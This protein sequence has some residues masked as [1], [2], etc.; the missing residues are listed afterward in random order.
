[1]T[2]RRAEYWLTILYVGSM[3]L[4]VVSVISLVTAWQ[5]WAW[6]LDSCIEVDCG[7]ILYGVN[8]FSTFLGGDVKLCHFGS[9]GLVPV[10][11]ISLCL[12]GYHGYRSCIH[13]D[14]DDP[15]RI[16]RKTY[17]DDRYLYKLD[18]LSIIISLYFCLIIYY[19]C[20]IFD[21]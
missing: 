2:P 14:L 11:I 15:K 17:D 7:C 19:C 9:Y 21:D 6:T 10:I 20:I 12:G 3:V 8:T 13:K 18:L 16:S 5:H 4:S 1:M